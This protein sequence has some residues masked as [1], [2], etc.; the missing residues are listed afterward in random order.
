MYLGAF[1]TS[2]VKVVVDVPAINAIP[3]LEVLPD[4]K[5]RHLRSR[6]DESFHFCHKSWTKP[7]R[8]PMRINSACLRPAVVVEDERIVA[9][10]IDWRA[11]AC[12]L[13]I[14]SPALSG[15]T[16]HT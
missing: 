12:I 7:F 6:N 8:Q 15:L 14:G 5:G 13:A 11:I 16:L 3:L 10:G 2:R 1:V 4:G 9:T